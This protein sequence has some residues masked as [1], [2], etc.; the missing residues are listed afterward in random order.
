MLGRIRNSFFTRILWGFIG[1][2]LLNMSVDSSDPFPDYIPEDLSFNDQ[3]SIIEILVEQV[4]G[5]ENAFE[6][7][8]DHDTEDHNKKK[9]IK[10]EL[11][12]HT[13]K[14]KEITHRYLTEKE[15]LCLHYEARLTKGFKEIDSPPPKA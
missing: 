11:L 5:F 7:Y 9:N 14:N 3:E 2:Y 15:M 6:E 4:L 1:L 13:T 8:D 12:V 10:I